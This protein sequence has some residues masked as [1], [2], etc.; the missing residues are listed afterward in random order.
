MIRL[1]LP[2]AV[3]LVFEIAAF[4]FGFQYYL[5]LRKRSGDVIPEM[6]RIWIIVGATAGALI[7]SRL[8]GAL[9]DPHWLHPISWKSAFTAFN[10]KSIV[11]GFFGGILGVE[12]VKKIVGEKNRSG[13]LFVFPIL[14]ALLIGRIGCLLTALNDHTAGGPTSLPWGIDYGDG[15]FRNPLPLYE[16]IYAVCMFFILR[17]LQQK[18]ILVPGALFKL[19]MVSYFIFRLINET[20]KDDYIYSWK[21]SAIQTVCVIALLYY[22]NVFF[23][24]RHLIKSHA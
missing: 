16:M 2:S 23:R 19:L 8:L 12:L 6:H 24:P 9:E 11:G 21:L 4:F 14:L 10:S 17:K 15:V 18:Q 1:V 5:F 13:D 7:G 22:A 20:F 3:H